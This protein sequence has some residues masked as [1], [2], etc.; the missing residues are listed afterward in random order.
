MKEQ[1]NKCSCGQMPKSGLGTNGL[2]RALCPKMDGGC[3]ESTY[4]FKTM[5]EAAEKW[6]LK[7]VIPR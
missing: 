2:Y 5:K 1:L 7:I 4:Q 3:G 6:N